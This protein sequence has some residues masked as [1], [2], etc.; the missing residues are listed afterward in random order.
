MRTS[1]G[2]Q[3]TRK[4]IQAMSNAFFEEDYRPKWMNGLELDFYFPDHGLA[5]EFNGDQHE[6]YNGLSGD[7]LP[8][9]LRD[10][11]KK[12]ICRSLGIKLISLEAFDLI[13]GTIKGKIK[14]LLP[15]RPDCGL[16]RDL[17]KRAAQ[18][19]SHLK[20]KFNSPTA[21]QK[22]SKGRIAAIE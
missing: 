17:D 22:G 12:E 9:I 13:Y 14:G 11:E 10:K 16:S 18:Y 20:T 8:Q 4:Y 5:I 2:Q 7:P 3:L 6:F 1:K 21:F 15:F 19:R